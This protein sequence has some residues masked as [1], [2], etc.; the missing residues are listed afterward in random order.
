MGGNFFDSEAAPRFG[1]IR[2]LVHVAY[3]F[4]RSLARAL[5]AGEKLCSNPGE[6]SSLKAGIGVT[7]STAITSDAQAESLVGAYSTC[8]ALKNADRLLK[9]FLVR[10]A[11]IMTGILSHPW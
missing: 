6:H 9:V 5:A 7:R 8:C 11:R 1:W 4:E 2:E 10:F 3:R